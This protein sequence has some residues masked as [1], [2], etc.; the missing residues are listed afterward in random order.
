MQV[1]WLAVAPASCNMYILLLNCDSRGVFI[2]VIKEI[3]TFSCYGSLPHMTLSA[4]EDLKS[5][6]MVCDSVFIIVSLVSTVRYL[7][8]QAMI[9]SK[10]LRVLSWFAVKSTISNDHLLSSIKHDTPPSHS[11][12]KIRDSYGKM[13]FS[14]LIRVLH[15]ATHMKDG[16]RNVQIFFLY[17]QHL[18]EAICT[19]R[20]IW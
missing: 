5:D 20:S 12:D 11:K 3:M 9:Q 7:G 13:P 4:K 15:Q 6:Q 19:V 10:S 8:K 2:S 17:T 14:Y 18:L 1:V 16:N